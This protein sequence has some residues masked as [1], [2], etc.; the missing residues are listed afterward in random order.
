MVF[1]GHVDDISRHRVSGWVGEREKPR[2]SVRVRIL[3]DGQEHGT[4]L[5]DQKRV[6]LA[7]H[8]GADANDLHGF[9]YHF[10]PPLPSFRRLTIDVFPSDSSRQIPGGHKTLQAPSLTRALFQPILVT[11]RGRAGTTLLMSWFKKHPEII[12]A[13]V[14]PFEVELACYYASAL[15]VMITYKL[16]GSENDPDF[17]AHAAETFQ[18]GRNPWNNPRL[19]GSVGGRELQGLFSDSIPNRLAGLFRN[20]IFDSYRAISNHTN[21]GGALYFA[22]KCSLDEDVRFGVRSMLGNVREV[23]MIRDP[24]DFLCSAKSFW[25]FDAAKALQVM[26]ATLPKYLK[27]KEAN[28]EDTMIVRYEDLVREEQQTLISISEH[29]GLSGTAGDVMNEQLFRVHATSK[30]PE[31]SVSRWK[32]DLSSQEIEDC[33]RVAGPFMEAFNYRL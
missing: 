20:I 1:A 21:K 5:A 23:V 26:R 29:I 2:E 14:Y 15:K 18:I 27:I 13:D 12:L 31:T 10:S 24:R 32:S 9:I 17:V 30:S 33:I 16:N 4:C 28:R 3:V 11:S 6:G 19:L 7:K 25:N 8:L 22:E